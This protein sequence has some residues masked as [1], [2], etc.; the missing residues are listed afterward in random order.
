MDNNP[1]FQR[2]S[3][4]DQQLVRQRLQEWNSKTLEEKEAI[5]ERE[6][7][8][9][10]PGSDARPGQGPVT[11]DYFKRLREMTPEQQQSFMANDPQFQRLSPE[12][13]AMIGQRLQEWNA[14]TPQEKE[15]MRGHEQQPHQE[16]GAQPGKGAA[17][18]DFFKRLREMPPEQQRRFLEN[19][20][21]FLNM[22]RD[23]QELIRERLREWNAK[24]PQ[25]KENIRERE[26][27][28]EG[29]SPE[30]KEEARKMLP[31]WLGLPPL[32][33][34]AV[35]E[36]FR[37]LRDLP[38][39]ERMAYL[40]SQSVRERFSPHERDI[41]EGMNKLLANSPGSGDRDR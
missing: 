4:E 40:D 1:Q 38:P 21:K 14:K 41:L 39:G 35:M 32:Q 16:N 13:Q 20:Q 37:H 22:T 34:Q 12:R 5:R 28:V 15:A 6:E 29:L 9:K 10:R 8:P 24:T 18:G 17:G 27:I 33:R 26:E 36:A 25:E 30:Q 31:Q 23:R 19:N 11:G 3:A 2:L 7:E